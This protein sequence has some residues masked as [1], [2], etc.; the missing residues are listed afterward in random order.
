MYEPSEL[1]FL[2]VVVFFALVIGG[3]LLAVAMKGGG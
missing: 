1:T 3:L 2:E